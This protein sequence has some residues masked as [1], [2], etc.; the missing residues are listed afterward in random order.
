MQTSDASAQPDADCRPVT[1]DYLTW[2]I[3]WVESLDV[4]ALGWNPSSPGGWAGTRHKW[5]ARNKVTGGGTVLIEIPAGWAG[6][7]PSARGSLEEFVLAGELT[8]GQQWFETWGYAS[9]P[10]GEPAMQYDTMTGATLLCF[11]D[12]NEFE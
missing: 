2:P 6:T 9:R 4:N 8:I 11:W 12:E 3:T 10:A 7:G 1:D 5:L